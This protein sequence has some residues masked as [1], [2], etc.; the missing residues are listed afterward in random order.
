MPVKRRTNKR[1]AGISENE[2]AWL[3]GDRECGFVQFKH[4][5]ELQVLWDRCGDQE[6]FHWEPGMR[7]PEPIV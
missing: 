7:Y 1:H 5:E 3:R 6:A 2:E 4:D